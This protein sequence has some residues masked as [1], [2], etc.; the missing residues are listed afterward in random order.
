MSRKCN[1]THFY[2]IAHTS[3]KPKHL[4]HPESYNFKSYTKQCRHRVVTCEYSIILESMGKPYR[5]KK[6]V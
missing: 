6:N 3:R 5:I 2:N 4:F 1:E